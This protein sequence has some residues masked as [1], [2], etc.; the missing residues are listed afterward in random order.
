[1]FL[2][3]LSIYAEKVIHEMHVFGVPR[4]HGKK[5]AVRY[6][7]VSVGNNFSGDTRKQAKKEKIVW[8]MV[9]NRRKMQEIELQ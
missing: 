5:F 1:M 9:E 6:K 8:K 3:G 4:I 7:K 2:L